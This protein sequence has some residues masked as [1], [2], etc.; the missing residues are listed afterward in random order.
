MVGRSKVKVRKGYKKGSEA[1]KHRCAATYVYLRPITM[2]S[3]RIFGFTLS[4]AEAPTKPSAVF[5][6]NTPSDPV[7]THAT[8]HT[9][10]HASGPTFARDCA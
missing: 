9:P 1:S 6:P 4:L 3:I 2:V 5:P 7:L 10:N 8:L